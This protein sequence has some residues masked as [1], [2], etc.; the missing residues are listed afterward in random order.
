VDYS[1]DY[2]EYVPILHLFCRDENFKRIEIKVNDFRPYFY[3]NKR[4][5]RT[6]I[7]RCSG[8]IT[9]LEPDFYSFSDRTE[10]TR[11]Y[12]RIPSKVGWCRKLLGEINIGTYEAD[13]LFPLRYMID[14]GIFSG[15]DYDIYSNRVRKGVEA[16]SRFRVMII[17]VEAYAKSEEDLEEAS[18]PIIV[19]GFYDSYTDKYYIHSL[20]GVDKKTL[21]EHMIEDKEVE[22]IVYPD[23]VQ[24]LSGVTRF[25]NNME[26]DVILTFYDWD[27]IYTIDRL[28]KLKLRAYARHMSPMGIVRGGSRPKIS[29]V[30]LMDIAEM[31]RTTLRKQKW[32]TLEF[33]AKQELDQEA[34]FHG[35]Q[36]YDMWQ[37]EP[38]NV[39]LRNLRDVELVKLLN[40]ELQ[41]VTYFDAI[42]RATGCNLRDTLLRSRVADILDLRSAKELGVVL[43]TRK[44]YKHWEY[45]GAKVFRCKKGIYRN[46]LVIDFSAM[47]PSIVR[48]LNIGYN[49][50]VPGKLDDGVFMVDNIKECFS[51]SDIPSFVIKA[52]DKLEPIRMP[53]K[54]KAREF[55][56][57]S[58][59]QKF[60]QAMSDGL[61]SVI[62]A[63][64]GKFGYSGDWRKHRPASRLYEPRVAALI[65]FVGRTLQEATYSFLE[66]KGYNVLYGDTDSEFVLLKTDNPEEHKKLIGIL[67]GF[68]RKF[69]KDELGSD[70]P[71]EIEKDKLFSSLVLITK[72]RY[73]GK[74]E[75][76]RYEWK[77]LEL[78][79]RDQ[80]VVT[81]EVQERLLKKILN[82]STKEDIREFFID[83]C[84]SFNG[85][86]IED[87]AIPLRVTKKPE[88]FKTASYHLKAFV[89]SRDILNISLEPGRRFYFIYTKEIPEKYPSTFK[90][91]IRGETK[92]HIVD[93]IAFNVVDE[94]PEGFVVD[95][96]KM[97]R[98]TVINKS[99]DILDIV[100]VNTDMLIKEVNGYVSLDKFR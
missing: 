26:P 52:F 71:L 32:E 42:R 33:I 67:N 17:D 98:K 70:T 74:R 87:I 31:Y 11:L 7:S 25:I 21:K 35:K 39:V 82:G 46:V 99:E 22:L 80:A 58:K 94:I 84:K 45:P 73:G 14:E 86:E 19:Y 95:Y 65:T 81:Q 66:S 54:K 69:M 8:L 91:T 68:I 53:H 3:V 1:L 56:Y 24:L 64:Y 63:E 43:P 89:Y 6:S 44:Y 60:H 9:G 93:G 92:Q 36:V 2:D 97:L 18:A 41:L 28:Y 88:T 30:Q 10:L 85:R 57:G 50:F 5:E 16:P 20:E 100:G 83:Y 15:I 23:E 79:K 40:D 13:I 62:N 12:T 48:A 78:V 61:K 49:T 55:P 59:E 37:T 96:E 90:V 76:D 77:G 29:G 4:D 75:S 47:Y 34:L 38:H 51:T 27:M 72:K